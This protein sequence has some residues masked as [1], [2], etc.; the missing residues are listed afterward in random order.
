MR[1]SLRKK[2]EAF[3]IIEVLIVLAIAGLIMLLVFLAVPT[4]QRNSRNTQRNGDAALFAAA[5]NECLSNRNGDINSCNT[6]AGVE[7]N[8][9]DTTK[10]RQ[11]TTRAYVAGTGTITQVNLQFGT[12]CDNAGSAA[13]AGAAARSFTLSFQTENTTGGGVNRCIDG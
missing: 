12:K 5:V 4:L 3:T 11:L 8:F 9:L 6:A 7:G 2:T 10:M 1:Y 13:S